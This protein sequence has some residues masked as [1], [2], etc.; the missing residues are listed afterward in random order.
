MTSHTPSQVEARKL[1]DAPDGAPVYAH[2]A[3]IYR[4]GADGRVLTLPPPVIGPRR[5]AEV[6]AMP[7]QAA[8]KGRP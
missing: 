2:V 5:I 8:G 6:V 4:V 3:F 1:S 7:V